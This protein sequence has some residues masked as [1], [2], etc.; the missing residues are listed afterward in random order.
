MEDETEERIITNVTRKF[1][2]KKLAKAFAT[3]SSGVQII[4]EMND[5]CER[6]A[7]AERQTQDALACYTEIYKGM[8]RS[9]RTKLDAF[10]KLARLL[11]YQSSQEC[12]LPAIIESSKEVHKGI[13]FI[14]RTH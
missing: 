4:E 8:K 13:N 11:R 12:L 1:T 7:N 2:A 9:I 6:F 3:T 10:L 14:S 5:S